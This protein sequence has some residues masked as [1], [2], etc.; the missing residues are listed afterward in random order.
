M[1]QSSSAD[2]LPSD[3]SGFAGGSPPGLGLGS[4]V[5]RGPKRK[6]EV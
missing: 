5:N 3:T 2:I 4:S 1:V 6:Q